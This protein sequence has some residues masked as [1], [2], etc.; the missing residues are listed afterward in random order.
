MNYWKDKILPAYEIRKNRRQK[1]GFIAMLRSH[2]GEKM[3][4]EECGRAIK[5]RNIVL[6]D[7]DSAEL[8]FTAHYDTCARLPF[9]NFITPLKLLIYILYQLLITVLLFVPPLMF[10]I[11]AAALSS[12][13]VVTECVLILTIAAEVWLILCGPA[14]PHTANDNTSGVTVVLTLA[15]LLI[16]DK[17]IA[18]VLFD[19]EELGL[20]GSAAFAKN[21]PNVRKNG[22]V[23][24]FDCVSDGDS[25]LFLNKLGSAV[26]GSGAPE[27][28]AE[29]YVCKIERNAR[30]ILP[31][32]GKTPVVTSKA[33]YPSDQMVFK[34]STAV[35]ALKKSR[36][37]ILYMDRIHTPRDTVFD[38]G[39]IDALV[40]LFK[41]I[42]L[43]H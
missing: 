33:L 18:F 30:E 41:D 35:A 38:E 25:I 3:R 42:K 2:F 6:G 28:K 36:L 15:D 10:A 32:Y 26:P 17:K 39:N 22:F 5:S 16:E 7:P 21:H 20:F 9:P 27:R 34:H 43:F 23:V 40:K 19:N 29:E 1:D 12:S 31:E 37:G 8:I 24:N 13:A 4:V 14:N 11:A